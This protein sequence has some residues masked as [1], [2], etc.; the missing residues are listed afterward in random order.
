MSEISREDFFQWTFF[1]LPPV[2]SGWSNDSKSVIN[3]FYLTDWV[4]RAAPLSS[5]QT[6]GKSQLPQAEGLV[7]RFY[8]RWT[9]YQEEV[10]CLWEEQGNSLFPWSFSLWAKFSRAQQGSLLDKVKGRHPSPHRS[11]IE[12]M[13]QM[14]AWKAKIRAMVRHQ[15]WKVQGARP[16][17]IIEGPES[18]VRVFQYGEKGDNAP[19]Y[20]CGQF[21]V[22]WHGPQELG[23]RRGPV[24]CRVRQ[25]GWRNGLQIHHIS[26]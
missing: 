16:G 8:I 12:H 3:L 24:N 17:Y 18:Q 15:I 9:K 22:R 21:L 11:F 6:N 26:F 23:E 10:E 7:E 4:F 5:P 13:K 20:K 25:P 14:Q 2:G 19:L 1:A